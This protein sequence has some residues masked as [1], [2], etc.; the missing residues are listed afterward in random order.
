MELTTQQKNL[1]V[2]LDDCKKSGMPHQHIAG[3]FAE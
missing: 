3:P 1:L 2:V